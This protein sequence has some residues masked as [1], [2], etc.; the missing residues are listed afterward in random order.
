VVACRHLIEAED[1][2]IRLFHVDAFTSVAFGGNPAAV[3]ILDVQKDEH[4]MLQ[5]AAE[6]NLLETAFLTAQ[7]DGYGLRWFTPAKE[8]SLCGHATLASAHVLWEEGIVDK[9]QG[10]HFHT[11]SGMLSASRNGEMVQLDFPARIVEPA[12]NDERINEAVGAEP[13]HTSKFRVP[14]GIVYLLEYENEVIVRELKPDFRRLAETDGRAF[15]A[16]SRTEMDG[17]DFVSR[18]FAPAVG[19][20]EDPVT[21]SAHCYLAPYWSKRL[22]KTQ[23]VGFQA[24][25]RSGSVRCRLVKDRVYLEGKAVTVFKG[26]LI[27]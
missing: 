9:L 20:N 17:H 18:Y 6:M 8:V 27:A 14:N 23:L 2:L 26:E 25:Q 3:C 12:R 5:V 24:S 16:T 11:L 7:T 10:I 1:R 13:T 21:G 15:I 19:I 4:W 22:G